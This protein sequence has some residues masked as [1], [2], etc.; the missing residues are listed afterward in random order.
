M[1][2]VTTVG[3]VLAN[4]AIREGCASAMPCH[5][6]VIV[7]YN[8]IYSGIGHSVTIGVVNNILF[9]VTPFY[10]AH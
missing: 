6:F 10:V 9:I 3:L 2:K 5:A 8:P 1:R 7:I 4:H